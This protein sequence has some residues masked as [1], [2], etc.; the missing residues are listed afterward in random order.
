MSDS[1]PAHTHEDDR[2]ASEAE[3]RRVLI[4]G[5]AEPQRFRRIFR[6]LPASPRCKLCNSPF[7]GWGGVVMRLIGRRQ[8]R[9]N[10][11]YCEPCAFQQPGGAEVDLSM[12][13]ADV[14]ASTVIAEG[15]PPVEY[16]RLIERFY[17]EATDVLVAE[18][19]LIDRLVGDQV[20]A[21]FVSGFGGAQHARRAIRAAQR[22]RRRATR[23]DR[24]GAFLPIGIGVHTGRAF[25]GVVQSTVEGL[26]DFTMLG[27]DVNVTARLASAAA[28][29]EILLSDAAFAAAGLE[30]GPLQHRDLELKGKSQPV[31]VYVVAA[32]EA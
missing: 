12:L 10:P 20:V 9:K 31:G 5:E 21:L 2:A 23:I 4:E 22:L 30:L 7:K 17:A 16:S 3:W 18:D 8:S 1:D 26:S 15:M 14:R 29:G 32:P 19:G 25:V 28:A 6:M 24:Q 27:D 11:R 13:F